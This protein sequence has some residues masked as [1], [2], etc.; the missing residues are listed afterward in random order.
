MTTD[1]RAAL[2]RG[3]YKA[4]KDDADPSLW[5]LY[6]LEADPGEREDLAE[7]RP[8]LLD[9]LVSS[10]NGWANGLS[11]TRSQAGPG[12]SLGGKKSETSST[13]SGQAR[14]ATRSP[15]P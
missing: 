14:G 10:W 3:R 1:R 7:S 9:E 11:E 12:S 5:R 4:K 2:V 15:S 8:E 13:T 6:D